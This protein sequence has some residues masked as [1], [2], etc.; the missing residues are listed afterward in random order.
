MNPG[1]YVMKD[2]PFRID[3]NSTV[4]GRDVVIAFTGVDS[5]LYLGS[6]AIVDLTSPT[7]GTYK[8]IQFFQDMASS[9][10]AWATMLGDIKLT[11]DGVMYFPT[12]DVW[13]GGGS[14]ITAKSP[15]YIFVAE[16]LWFQDNTIIDVWQENSRNID[17]PAPSADLRVAPRPMN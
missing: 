13:I 17:V 6:G 4:T 9:T 15:S 14:I 3:S 2:G 10:D 1:V 7:T 5:T 12:Q 16:K 11:F 8:N